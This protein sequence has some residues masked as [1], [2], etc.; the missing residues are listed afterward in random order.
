M[1]FKRI[2]YLGLTI[3][4]TA[5]D[6]A[7]MAHFHEIRV[8]NESNTILIL[9]MPHNELDRHKVKLLQCNDL[10]A[11]NKGDISTY[12][13][14]TD[15]LKGF[16]LISVHCKA[17]DSICVYSEDSVLL[18]TWYAPLRTEDDS[19]HDF[20]NKNSWRI[21]SETVGD[22]WRKTKDFYYYTFVIREEDLNRP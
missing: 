10:S 15:D 21:T 8:R 9:D 7:S 22:G 1:D 4:L 20:F 5:C 2:I 16:D 18:Q 19:V 13:S 6:P 3:V 14:A 17:G 11:E 12:L